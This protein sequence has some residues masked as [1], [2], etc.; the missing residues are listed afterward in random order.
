MR[1]ALARLQEEH[2]TGSEFVLSD[3]TGELGTFVGVVQDTSLQSFI[4]GGSMD[5]RTITIVAEAAQFTTASV[6]P[7]QGMS[8]L[9]DGLRYVVDSVTGRNSDAAGWTIRAVAPLK[10]RK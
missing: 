9:H 10:P 4:S 5:D 2:A 7:G 3:A 6:E 1:Q 8:V